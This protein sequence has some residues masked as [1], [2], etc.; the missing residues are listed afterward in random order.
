MQ[1]E[2]SH[3]PSSLVFGNA[4]KCSII[5]GGGGTQEQL[6][7]GVAGFDQTLDV[8]IVTHIDVIN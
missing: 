8:E 5:I 6:A 2:L 7:L 1:R 4:R 3:G